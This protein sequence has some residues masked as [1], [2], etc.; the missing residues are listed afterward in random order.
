MDPSIFFCLSL[1][2]HSS[3]QVLSLTIIRTHD[4][5]FVGSLIFQLTFHFGTQKQK[6][7]CRDQCPHQILMLLPQDKACW[8]SYRTFPHAWELSQLQPSLVVGKPHSHVLGIPNNSH[9]PEINQ[10][11]RLRPEHRL[12]CLAKELLTHYWE[13]SPQADGSLVYFAFRLHDLC[14]RIRIDCSSPL[15]HFNKYSSVMVI[16]GSD[17]TAYLTVQ[18]LR[19]RRLRN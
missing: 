19:L 11:T 14:P 18:K 10:H 4:R 13:Q 6:N 2:N 8:D 1:Q 7:A 3:S 5:Q 12:G 16:L 15:C 9:L 17:S